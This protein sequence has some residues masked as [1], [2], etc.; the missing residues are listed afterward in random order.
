VKT[1][2]FLGFG[3]MI[4][5]FMIAAGVMYLT[6]TATA[7][8]PGL[9][10]FSKTPMWVLTYSPSQYGAVRKIKVRREDVRPLEGGVLRVQRKGRGGTEV[11]YTSNWALETPTNPR[12]S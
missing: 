2:L 10:E 3:L 7:Q 4:V 5:S 9:T 12:K 8:E 1:G 6:E 11:I